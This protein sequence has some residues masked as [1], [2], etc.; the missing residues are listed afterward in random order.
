MPTDFIRKNPAKIQPKTAPKVLIPYNP[1]T[2]FP[3][4][5][6]LFTIDL[7][8]RGSVPPMKAVG[9]RIIK[10]HKKNFSKERI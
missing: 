6:N 3:S 4:H 5:F 7:L 8:K 9:M 10:K 1:P 2:S